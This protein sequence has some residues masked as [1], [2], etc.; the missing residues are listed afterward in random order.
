MGSCG[1]HGH[2]AV[3]VWRPLCWCSACALYSCTVWIL[4][5]VELKRSA[6]TCV[7]VDTLFIRRVSCADGNCDLPGALR[8]IVRDDRK[9]RVCH[10]VSEVCCAC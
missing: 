10:V 7:V 5:A 2:D 3:R 6:V 1:R 4:W 8:D 9:V